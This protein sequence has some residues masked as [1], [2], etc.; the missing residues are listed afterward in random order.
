MTFSY[1]TLAA[2]PVKVLAAA[3]E[4]VVV[5]A[6]GAAALVKPAVVAVMLDAALEEV[7][8]VA[9]AEPGAEVAAEVTLAAVAVD[10]ELATA[11]EGLGVELFPQAEAA[12]ST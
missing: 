1:S 12:A 10:S 11:L 8:D 2:A 3:E 5:V 7:A 4:E 6:T 9:P